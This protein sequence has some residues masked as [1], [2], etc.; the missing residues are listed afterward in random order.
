MTLSW[1]HS[2][3]SVV[4]LFNDY[5]GSIARGNDPLRTSANRKGVRE[6]TVVTTVPFVT[7]EF[8]PSANIASCR[9]QNEPT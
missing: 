3:T 1:T 8:F 9:H 2:A 6:A 5:I 7:R 4:N